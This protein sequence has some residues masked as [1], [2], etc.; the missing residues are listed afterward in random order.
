[1]NT[2]LEP[3]KDLLN[4]VKVAPN[5]GGDWNDGMNKIG[6]KGFGEF[7]ARLVYNYCFKTFI[8]ICEKM[9]DFKK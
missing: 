4:L 7:M 8:P 1:M 6:Y 3:L 5:G 9:E 2:V